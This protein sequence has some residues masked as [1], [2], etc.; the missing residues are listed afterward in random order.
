MA[1][2]KPEMSLSGAWTWTQNQVLKLRRDLS[3]SSN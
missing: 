1:E 3:T 2:N